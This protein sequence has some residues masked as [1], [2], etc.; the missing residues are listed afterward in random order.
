MNGIDILFPHSRRKFHPVIRSRCNNSLVVRYDIKTQ[1]Q[2]CYADAHG[3]LNDQVTQ[4]VAD[5]EWVWFVHPWRG[6]WGTRSSERAE[7]GQ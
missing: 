7:Q 6:L 4:I 3:M 2:R 1:E 5:D